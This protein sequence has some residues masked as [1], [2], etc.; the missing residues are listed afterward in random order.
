MNAVIISEEVGGIEPRWY[1]ECEECG[2]LWQ[3]STDWRAEDFARQHSAVCTDGEIPMDGFGGGP[4][5]AP[6]DGPENYAIQ[7]AA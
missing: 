1:V 4:E 3:F 6:F 5:L 2:Q 7:P